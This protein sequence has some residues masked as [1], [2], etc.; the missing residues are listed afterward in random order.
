MTPSFYLSLT[1]ERK[2][3]VKQNSSCERLF[4]DA[5]I[6]WAYV[7]RNV[8]LEWSIQSERIYEEHMTF[9]FILH[10]QFMYVWE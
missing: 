6:S 5:N 4:I 2:N 10:A 7:K 1:H 8:S 9:C 3:E